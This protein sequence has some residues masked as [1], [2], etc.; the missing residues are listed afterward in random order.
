MTHP[1]TRR[2]F[3]KAGA[4][5]AAAAAAPGA[6]ARRAFAATRGDSGPNTLVSIFL[7]G[8]ADPLN[9]FVPYGDDAYARAR[10][11]IA[12]A[13]VPSAA[14]ASRS[15]SEAMPPL[16]MTGTATAAASAAVAATLAPA[17]TPSRSMSV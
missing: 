14:S 6:L 2:D 17:S 15:A 7:R 3:L 10:P 9:V 5:F 8:G 11:T 4:L 12:P 1:P 13:M 16:A